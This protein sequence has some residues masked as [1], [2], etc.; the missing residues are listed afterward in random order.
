MLG[1]GSTAFGT[2]VT[3]LSRVSD[4]L[5]PFIC[6]LSTEWVPSLPCPGLGQAGCSGL[7]SALGA[8]SIG[9]WTP[10]ACCRSQRCVLGGVQTS[11]CQLWQQMGKLRP[12][13]GEHF[14]GCAARYS[15]SVCLLDPGKRSCRSLA[16]RCFL[17]CQCF[18]NSF[19]RKN[20]KR[21][22]KLGKEQCGDWLVG[23]AP[24]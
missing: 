16:P 24:G 15:Q 5:C 14:L 9:G 4:C 18:P 1:D 3:T 23:P 20:C 17:L 8:Q 12:R 13:R 19:F 2:H 6:S 21:L 7:S 22:E 11:V 10:H